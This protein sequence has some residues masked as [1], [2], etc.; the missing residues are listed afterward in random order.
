MV[1]GKELVMEMTRAR[2]GKELVRRFFEALLAVGWPT[3][4]MAPAHG[5]KERVRRF[6]ATLLVVGVPTAVVFAAYVGIKS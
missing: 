6:F 3:M 2:S 5:V 1:L 4:G